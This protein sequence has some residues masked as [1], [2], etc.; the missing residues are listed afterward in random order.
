M[1]EE[2]E[3]RLEELAR[4]KAQEVRPEA[5]EDASEENAPPPLGSYDTTIRVKFTFS[6]FPSLNAA[7][8]RVSHLGRF[9]EIDEGAVV[10]SVRPKKV[11]K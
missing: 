9:G 2:R 6:A 10:L 4:T 3:R 1:K 8:A 5:D 11:G 7:S